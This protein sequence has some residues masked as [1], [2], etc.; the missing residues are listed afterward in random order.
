MSHSSQTKTQYIYIYIYNII[1]IC[2]VLLAMYSF[3]NYYSCVKEVS[4]ES[5]FMPSQTY[6]SACVHSGYYESLLQS[7]Y[8]VEE[9]IQP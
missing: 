5:Y 4:M 9:V 7:V 2:I 3:C 8:K 1:Y 6:R